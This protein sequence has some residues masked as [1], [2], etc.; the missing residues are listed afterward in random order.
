[1]HSFIRNGPW[2]DLKQTLL[3]MFL[4]TSIY[5][6]FYIGLPNRPSL[7]FWYFSHIPRKLW[8]HSPA[9]I[10]TLFSDRSYLRP[11]FL[12]GLIKI[13]NLSCMLFL[14]NDCWC[15]FYTWLWR[16]CK[17]YTKYWCILYYCLTFLNFTEFKSWIFYLHT[18]NLGIWMRKRGG[19]HLICWSA[20]CQP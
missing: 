2:W 1:M 17:L 13:E 4:L 10:V 15:V 16:Y 5:R 6:P 20:S 12:K 3:V 18:G 7:N 14:N 9:H 8:P 19:M 11:L